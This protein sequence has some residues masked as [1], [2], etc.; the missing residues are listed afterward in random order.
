MISSMAAPSA[1][2]VLGCLFTL[3]GLSGLLILAR[4]WLRLQIQSQP[5]AL[6]DGLLVIA[7]FSCLAQAVLVILMRNEDVLHPDINYTL[8]N[9]EADPAKVEHVRK[10]IW[11]TIFP[12]FSALYFC[13]FALLATYLQLFP[14]FMTVLRKM[15]Y[16]TIVY[17]VSGYIVSISLQLFLCWPIERNWSF[18]NP[19]GLCSIQIMTTIFH[20]SWAFHFSANLC[21]LAMPF[22]ILKG[23]QMK[24]ST[25][26][27]ISTTFALGLIDIAVS[28][29]RF[30][31]IQ[32]EPTS[33]KSLTM[34]QIWAILDEHIALIVACIPSLRQYLRLRFDANSAAK[35]S[36]GH[37]HSLHNRHHEANP[38]PGGDDESGIEINRPAFAETC[39]S[40][41]RGRESEDDSWSDGK[42]S[43]RSD[44]ELVPIQ[45]REGQKGNA[46]RRTRSV[47]RVDQEFTITT[48]VMS[49]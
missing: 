32:L 48:T 8:F 9:W 45:V 19:S 49:P 1:A 6:S 25:M 47:I 24:R 41:R 28:L 27:G 3:L 30:L 31:S 39:R 17:C 43:N 36:Y 34:I 15:L 35:R 40:G 46:S 4:L 10:L 7:W 22:F 12:F 33:S 38:R 29:A 18:L 13:K 11:V 44:V 37:N 20:V 42:K 23:L 26:I 14:P 21:I 16:A 5:L 2:G